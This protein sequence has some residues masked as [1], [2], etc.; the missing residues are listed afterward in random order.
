MTTRGEREAGLGAGE[1]PD[2]PRRIPRDDVIPLGPHRVGLSL[3]LAQ[4]YGPALQ[5]YLAGLDEIVLEVGVAEVEAV[6]VAGHAGAVGVPV[7][8]V[9]GWRFLAQQ[10]VVDDVRP[11]QVVGAQ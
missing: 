11:D 2:L 4:L 3:Y 10:V 6:G 9:E 8:E 7:E 1:L 5:F